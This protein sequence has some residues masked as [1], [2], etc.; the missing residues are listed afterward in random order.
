[1]LG[2]PTREH[3][4]KMRGAIAAVYAEAKTSHESSPLGS[5]FG[6]STAILK[7]DKYIALHNTVVNGHSANEKLETTWSFLHPSRPDTYEDT[8]L[9]VHIDVSRRKREAQ[10]AELITQ[11]ETYEK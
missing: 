8:I 10:R 1:M 2:R 4:N 11:Y 3:V 7:K 5:K 9:A 6:F